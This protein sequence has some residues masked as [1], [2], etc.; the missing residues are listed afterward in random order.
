MVN[1]LM[2]SNII[3]CKKERSKISIQKAN[4]TRLHMDR[5]MGQR[6]IV[7]KLLQLIYTIVSVFYD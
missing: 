1:L 7:L 6:K 5:I 3:K 4:F 2:N